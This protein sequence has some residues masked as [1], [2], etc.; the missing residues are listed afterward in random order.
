MNVAVSGPNPIKKERERY[1]LDLIFGAGS[2][3]EFDDYK[4]GKEENE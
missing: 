4:K 3:D 2:G 1:V